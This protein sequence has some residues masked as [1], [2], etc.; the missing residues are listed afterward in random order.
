M[1]RT[2][3]SLLKVSYDNK[4]KDFQFILD[5]IAKGQMSF[6][7]AS[8]QKDV[9]QKV[10]GS[11]TP[12]QN[13]LVS[14]KKIYGYSEARTIDSEEFFLLKDNYGHMFENDDSLQNCSY[15]WHEIKLLKKYDEL[16]MNCSYFAYHEYRKKIVIATYGRVGEEYLWT[17]SG[18]EGIESLET[19]KLKPVLKGKVEEEFDHF[20]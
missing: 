14:K 6:Q 3:N 5:E 7:I 9:S 19:N 1:Y 8:Y 11:L 15:S 2:L 17:I 13:E 20:A 4:K 10:I 18:T 16:E 12:E